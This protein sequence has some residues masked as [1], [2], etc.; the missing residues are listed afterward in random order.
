MNTE[1]KAHIFK[2]FG[3]VRSNALAR[4]AVEKFSAAWLACF[5]VMSRGDLGF[6]F[7]IEH[8]RI[9]GICGAVG[10]AVAVALLAQM[11]PQTDSSA[12]HATISAITTFIGDVVARPMHF[13]PYWAEPA[14]TAAMSAVIAIA[15]WQAKRWGV[16]LR[17][18][19]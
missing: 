7:S 17:N 1:A 16:R 8:A 4:A 12:R 6:A 13:S 11:D 15:I 19:R 9:A 3:A 10:A 2:L 5:L 18:A 14:L